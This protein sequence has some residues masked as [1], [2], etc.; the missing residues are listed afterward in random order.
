MMIAFGAL[1]GNTVATRMTWLID[2]LETL[3]QW[4]IDVPFW[5]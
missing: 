3:A 2:R 4:I 1:F 5:H